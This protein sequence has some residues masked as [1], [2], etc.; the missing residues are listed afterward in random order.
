MLKLLKEK[1]RLNET[2][3]MAALTIFCAD[4]RH[5]R[6][7]FR[8]IFKSESLGNDSFNGYLFKYF[9]LVVSIDTEKEIEFN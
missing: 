9:V 6:A 5:R 2:R 8:P 3:F 1:N 4:V 7:H